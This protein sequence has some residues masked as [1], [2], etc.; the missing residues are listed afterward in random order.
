MTII[1]NS[2]QLQS[3]ASDFTERAAFSI[4]SGSVKVRKYSHYSVQFRFALGD[5]K[6][7]RFGFG[8]S[9]TKITRNRL[10]L[11]NSGSGLVRFLFPIQA[12][13]EISDLLCPTNSPKQNAKKSR[14]FST[15]FIVNQVGNRE[16]SPLYRKFPTY[17]VGVFGSKGDI[18][19]ILD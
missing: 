10:I 3:D 14:K 4:G 12:I 18:G 11:Q 9:S 2:N 15:W 13:S 1:L 16:T 7:I 8:L 5:F 6:K 17:F 19:L